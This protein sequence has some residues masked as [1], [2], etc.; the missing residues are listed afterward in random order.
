M[1]RPAT[2]WTA[3][4]RFVAF[5]A[6]LLVRSLGRVRVEGLEDLPVEGPLIVVSNHISNVDP[7]LVGGWLAPVLARRPRFLAKQALFRGPLGWFLRSQGVI[8]VRS[9]SSDVEAYRLA[10][11]G[12]DLGGVVVIFPEGTRSPDGVL[13][14]ARPGVALLA[15]RLGVPVLPVGV[16]NT[17]MLLGRGRALPRIGTRVTLRV[18]RPFTL[19]LDPALPRRAALAAANEELMQRIAALLDPRHRGRFG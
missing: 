15:T 16:S 18:G 4:T 9:G 6:R 1:R 17:D 2:G 5:L 12:L 8:P 11:A 19:T 14:E 3:Y 13:A 10:K 7:P